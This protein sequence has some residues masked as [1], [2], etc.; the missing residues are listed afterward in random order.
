VEKVKIRNWYQNKCVN[1]EKAKQTQQTFGNITVKNSVIVNMVMSF[2]PVWIIAG[3][4]SISVLVAG[5]SNRQNESETTS[6]SVPAT[7]TPVPSPTPESVHK[8]FEL[9]GSPGPVWSLAWSP[10][11][12]MLA[13][14]GFD[15]V[16]LW[17]AQTRKKLGTLQGHTDDVWGVAWSPD[18]RILAA[19]QW[20]GVV[21][22]WNAKTGEQVGSLVSNPKERNDVNGL[23]WSPDGRMLASAHQDGKIR[24]WHP[25]DNDVPRTLEGHAGAAR[26]LAWSPNGRF[27]ASTGI[28][29]A[30]RLWD[31]K[32]G[33]QLSSLEDLSLWVLS[34]AWSPDGKK[35][36]AG[37]GKYAEQIG[38]AV[39]VWAVP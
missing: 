33:Q 4:V 1:N 21:Y 17:D 25:R 10:D 34:V 30:V 27:L 26:G 38:G 3:L 6:T 16:K 5:C 20:N 29:S 31:V 28:D 32:T 23:A 15:Q 19:R 2:S 12:R 39:V 9:D 18:G 7:D 8:L 36:A 37:N 24:L 13:S 35:I 14:A 11:G 22:L